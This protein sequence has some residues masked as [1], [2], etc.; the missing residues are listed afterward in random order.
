MKY[1][2]HYL[3]AINLIIKML[4]NEFVSKDTKIEDVSTGML[5]SGF[6]RDTNVKAN[7]A[8]LLSAAIDTSRKTGNRMQEIEV[9]PIITSIIRT[10]L[11]L[12]VLSHQLLSFHLDAIEDLQLRHRLDNETDVFLQT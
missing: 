10:L 8:T 2:V 11:L 4:E 3:P 1:F 7:L 5:P 12:K 6:A 9:P